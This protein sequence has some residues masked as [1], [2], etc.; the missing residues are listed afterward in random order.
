MK[1]NQLREAFLSYFEAHSHTRVPSAS[2]VPAGD[3]TLLLTN[4]GMVPFKDYFTGVQKPPYTRA[5]ST[6]KCVRA[7]GKHNDLD[8]VGYTARHHTFFEMLGNFSFGDYFKEQAIEFAWNFLTKELKL[9]AEK[10]WITVHHSDSEAE[11]I[12]KNKIKV[13]PNRFS[14][15]G[16]KDNFWSMG[17]TGPC[18]PCTEIFYDHGPGV[19]GGPPG[20]P[21]EDGDR[22][23]EIW[24]LVFMQF[25]RSSDGTMTSLPKPSVDTGMGIE[26]IAAVLQG[27]HSNYEIDLFTAL[28]EKAKS[29]VP[30]DNIHSLRVLADHIRSVSFMIADGILPSNDGRGY[31][32]RRI[33]RRALRHGHNLGQS[34]P[35]F[36]KMVAEL[37]AQMGDAFGELKVKQQLIESTILAEEQQFGRT[38]EGGMKLLTDAIEQQKFSQV[39]GELAF[40]LYDT[41]G[42]PLDLT[43]DVAREKG[44]TVDTAGF[45]VQMAE[46]KERARSASKFSVDLCAPLLKLR[47]STAFTGYD[48]TSTAAVVKYCLVN[49]ELVDEAGDTQ[50]TLVLDKTPF[51]AESGGQVG[52][53]GEISGDGF[54]FTVQ[55]TQKAGQ[56]II[57][58]GQLH[59]KLKVGASATAQIDKER[60]DHIR[61][62]HSVTHL[63]HA[64][65][66]KVLGTHVEQRG[67]LVAPTYLRFDFTHPKAL[68]DVQLAQITEVVE[69]EILANTPVTTKELPFE[70]AKAQGAMALFGEKYEHDV[71]MLTMGDGYSIEL[72]GGTHVKRTGDIGPFVI[73]SETAISSGIRRIE[74]VAGLMAINVLKAQQRVLAQATATLGCRTEELPEKLELLQ[75]NMKKLER[76]QGALQQKQLAAKAQ[77]LSSQAVDVGGIQVICTNV[78]AIDPKALRS[79]ADDLKERLKPAIIVLVA[80]NDKAQFVVSVTKDI[81]KD[82]PAGKLVRLLAEIV[83]GKGGGRDDMAQAGGP[84]VSKIPTALE[85]VV[86][87]IKAA[88]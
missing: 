13:D 1:V 46:Q 3:A 26:R 58:I 76:E 57:H 54:S 41:Y 53:T 77:D 51:Y 19:P 14:K 74:A 69:R 38:L 63:L 32:L 79:M 15:C 43:Q 66:R 50:A 18:G 86:P 42:F 61:R 35:F 28:I 40:K 67:S 78:G 9:P 10:L 30:G 2:L 73:Q 70:E 64:A 21:E 83:G 29:L 59:G 44:I 72:C 37:V 39:P 33:L 11:D 68:T 80:Q 49:S 6:Q 16:D 20:S 45:D 25:E 60:R 65:L 31:V 12:W 55:D 75:S 36:H 82:Y 27:V 34:K 47:E 17:D 52:D 5:T 23:I 84:D 48:A 4:A 87:W 88:K 7:G 71:R 8:N 81:A 22:Y 62:H 85:A 56:L 24:N